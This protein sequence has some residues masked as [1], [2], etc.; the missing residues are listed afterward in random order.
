MKFNI[1]EQNA[2]FYPS[3]IDFENLLKDVFSK[4]KE[5]DE[6]ITWFLCSEEQLYK[7]NNKFF[8]PQLKIPYIPTYNPPYIPFNCKPIY[9]LSFPDEKEIYISTE[10]IIKHFNNKFLNDNII[11]FNLCRSIV[12]PELP[13]LVDVI[14]DEFTHIKTK[15]DHG[16]KLYDT[17]F[18]KYKNL[19]INKTTPE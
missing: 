12:K 13:F 3:K 18:L 11:N 19:Y 10:T 16:T 5:Y 2:L 1:I 8:H 6:D 14:I 9:W 4:I 17:T 7:I 15:K